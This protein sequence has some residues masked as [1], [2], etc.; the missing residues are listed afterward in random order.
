MG[1]F[2]SAVAYVCWA[3]ALSIASQTS[4]VSNFMFL[5]PFIA[6]GLGY[7]ILGERLSL[8]NGIGGICILLGLLLFYR[9]KQNEQ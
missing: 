7:V 4:E 2:S 8:Q 9:G 5:T 3:K 6:S 1:V